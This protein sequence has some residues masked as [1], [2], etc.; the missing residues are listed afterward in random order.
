M[1]HL[2]ITFCA[3]L[4]AAAVGCQKQQAATPASPDTQSQAQGNGAT[5]GAPTVNPSQSPIANPASPL[6]GW[7]KFS[8]AEGKFSAIFPVRPQEIDKTSQGKAAGA[9]MH[10]FIAQKDPQTVYGAGYCDY[11]KVN[12]PK[13]LLATIE[14]AM[15][16]NHNGKITSYKAMQVDGNPATQFE[17]DFGDKPDSS[18]VRLISIGQ[19]IYILLGIYST[20]QSHPE[21]RDAFF[22]SFTLQ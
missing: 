21:E 10:L 9:Q 22:N 11:S 5:P 18:T 3:L 17:F 8:S 14:A 7:E 4:L 1:R 2:K 20:G 16:K 19:R 6:Y 12:D 13:T 15:V